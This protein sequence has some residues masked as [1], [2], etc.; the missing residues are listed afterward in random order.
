[1]PQFDSALSSTFNLAGK[2]VHRLGF[3][4]M[5]LADPD[6]WGPPTDRDNSIRVARRVVELGLDVIDTADVYGFGATEDIL[7]EA[8]HPYPEHLLIATKVGQVQTRPREWVPLGRPE[9]L[10]QQC[11]ASLRRLQVERIDLLQLHRVDPQVPLEDQ[12]GELKAL[13]DEGKIGAVGLSEVSVEQID[14]ARAIVEIVSVENIYNLAVRAWD[15]VVDYCTRERIAFL[16]WFPI[17]SGALVAAEGVAAQIAK[18][19][20]ATPAQLALAWLLARSDVMIPIPG[21][22]SIAH[23]EEN[24]MA[25]QVKLTSEQFS[26]LLA[27]PVEQ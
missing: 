26:A 18:E 19:V 17:A 22:S 2:T 6:I 16:P 13:Q 15:P 7:R 27:L 11:E 5:R 23:L 20:G 24:T 12:V 9:Y 1:M 25:D 21:T 10:R 4:A 14:T 3:G 8:L